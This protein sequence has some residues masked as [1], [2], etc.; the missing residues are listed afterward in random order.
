MAIPQPAVRDRISRHPDQIQAVHHGLYVGDTDA[1]VDS[2]GRRF[3]SIR[4]FSGIRYTGR[5]RGHF[6]CRNSLEERH[7]LTL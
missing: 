7:V 5:S 4:I 3:G 6:Q 1:I 2:P